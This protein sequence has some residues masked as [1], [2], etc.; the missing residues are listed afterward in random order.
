M[1][2]FA[3]MAFQVL[4]N[5][6]IGIWLFACGPHSEKCDFIG[7]YLSAEGGRTVF[8]F[9]CPSGVKISANGPLH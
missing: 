7:P 3:I 9:C 6:I 5:G 1:A 4:I 2:V 8:D